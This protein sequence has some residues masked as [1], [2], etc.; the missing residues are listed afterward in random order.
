MSTFKQYH[1]HPSKIAQYTKGK[2]PNGKI[3]ALPKCVQHKL[4]I[5]VT[6]TEIHL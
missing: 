2:L 4:D 5:A 6:A 1:L 3:L